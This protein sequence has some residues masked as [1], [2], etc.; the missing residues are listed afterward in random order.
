[1]KEDTY[2]ISSSDYTVQ[3]SFVQSSKFGHKTYPVIEIFDVSKSLI[4]LFFQQRFEIDDRLM[5]PMENATQ[6]MKIC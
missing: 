4:N 2:L 6:L 1:M 5:N 3:T